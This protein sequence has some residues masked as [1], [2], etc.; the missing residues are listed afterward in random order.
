MLSP[1]QEVEDF[2]RFEEIL[3][4]LGKNG[5]G[6]LLEEIKLHTYLPYIQRLKSKT[7]DP[8]PEKLRE[9]FE[10]LGPTFIK[11]GQILSE[12]PDII[13]EKYCKELEKLQNEV[14][15][16][17]FEKVEEIV[18]REIDRSKIEKIEEQPLAAASIAQVHRARL[19]TGEEV[20]LKIRR[21]GIEEQMEKDLDIITY[22]ARKT[23]KHVDLGK[24]FLTAEAEEFA[25]WTR[26]EL[27]FRKEARNMEEFSENMA[28][29][30]DIRVPDVYTDLTTEEVLTME[31]VDSVKVDN[32]E[33]IRDME[34]D[35]EKIAKTGI[36]AFI[37]QI[38][39]D[40]FLHADPHPSN[41]KVT[42]D[43]KLLFLDFGMMTR[44]GKS[45]QK[46]LGF[47]MK[48]IGEGDAEK[49]LQVIV[50]MSSV[51]NDA[52]LDTLQQ[53][54]ET[55]L[56]ELQGSTIEEH[57]ISTTLIQLSAKSAKNGVYLPTK[58]TLIGK[59]ILTMEGIGLKIYPDFEVQNE[60]KTQVEKLLLKQNSPEKLLKQLSFD[61]IENDD[62]LTQLPSKINRKL[63]E[64]KKVE[65]IQRVETRDTDNT[66]L[67]I[68]V[69]LVISSGFV[70]LSGSEN[71]MVYIGV[72]GFMTA[73]YLT[74]RR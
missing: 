65:N 62:L 67:I 57:S 74:A 8:G 55:E 32:V 60:F 15:A 26:Q 27:N 28:D 17:S 1:K 19:K 16:F 12:R 40:G 56:L 68:T 45:T 72:I 35:E 50:K 9:T 42:K 71:L 22:L 49:L 23:D 5:F 61:L 7:K 33:A 52:D 36:R 66:T 39:R 4:I 44:I 3:G 41:F 37:K 53:E 47:L 10:Q 38:L 64:R 58:V 69:L 6:Y 51:E 24:N 18:E 59:G 48:Y 43:G 30:E 11:F 54:I 21:P 34:L 73:I 70:Y 63:E 31:Y 14:P 13:P 20:V 29:E 46:Q 25:S 2:K